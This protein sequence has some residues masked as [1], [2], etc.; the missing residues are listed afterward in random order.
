ML[1]NFLGTISIANVDLAN[2]RN[3]FASRIFR[4][5]SPLISG[6]GGGMTRQLPDT[7]CMA[8]PACASLKRE[9]QNLV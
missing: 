3:A 5:G 7:L 9:V 2:M 6:A 1:S 4:K 8:E